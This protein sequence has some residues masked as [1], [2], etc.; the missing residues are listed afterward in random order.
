MTDT[1][2]PSTPLRSSSS[3]DHVLPSVELTSN[4]SSSGGRL[5]P[6]SSADDLLDTGNNRRSLTPTA[7]AIF[8]NLRLSDNP[9]GATHASGGTLHNGQTAFEL[10]PS[11][12]TTYRNLYNA[13]PSPAAVLSSEPIEQRP[14]TPS[15]PLGAVGAYLANL[16][17]EDSR[18]VAYEGSDRNR[19]P[20][21]DEVLSLGDGGEDNNSYPFD[22]RGEELF[23][24]PIYDIRLQDALRDVRGQLAD[25][26]RCM[27]RR[28]QAQDITTV[29]HNL[30]EQTL[31]ASRF[32]YPATR[33]VGFIGDS[34]MGKS[35]VINSILDQ[36]G[37]ARSNGDGAACTTVVTEFRSIDEEH[38]NSYTVEADF[39]DNTEI[40]ELLE[41]LLSAVRGYYTDA[42]REVSEP[43]EQENIRSAA[44][45]AWDTLQSLFPNQPELTLDF[46]SQEGQDAVEPIIARLE[47]WAMAGQDSR[48]GGRVNLQYSVVANNAEECMDQL[49]TIMA[50]PRDSDRPALWPFVKLI[51]VYLRSPVLRTGLIL[52]DLPGFRDLNYARVRATERY[53]RHSCD[54]VFIDV[55]ARETART[56]PGVEAR[57]I[58]DL[59]GRIKAVE[60]RIRQV[61]TLRRQAVGNRSQHLSAEQ[62]NLS[63]QKEALELELK[64]FLISRR[65]QRVTESLSRAWGS[66]TR[67][68]CVSN[69]LYAD[70]R[71]T[72]A[73]QASAYLELSGIK[74]LR[75][76]CQSVPADAQ[77]RAT[78]SFLQ[79]Q[80]PALLGSL[81]LWA[82]AR[83][84]AVTASRAETL[85]G[86]LDEASQTL[87]RS[88]TSRQSL[89]RLAQ[90]SLEEQFAGL[91]ERGIRNSRNEWRNDAINASRDWATW[92]HMTYAA[93][94]RNYGTYQTRTQPYRCWNEEILGRGITQLSNKWDVMLDFLD[95]KKD[96]L[97]EDVSNLFQ[98]ICDTVE[99][100]D[101]A[102]PDTLQMLIQNMTMRQRCIIHSIQ[103]SF[104]DLI[105]ATGK[106]RLDTTGGHDSSYIAGIMR[107]VYNS[108]R[109][110]YG[111]GSD[112][113]RKQIMDR[114]LSSSPLFR[115]FAT[116]IAGDFQGL[117]E[118][119]F[120]RLDQ[121]LRDEFS[122]LTQDLRVS[123][124][125]ERDES[126]AGRDPRHADELR[127]KVE[128]IQ[129]TLAHAC[130]IVTQVSQMAE[131]SD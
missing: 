17:L 63:E 102:A 65:N 84:D 23:R 122:N 94:C 95:D 3:P 128:R 24:A 30:Y 46:V 60:R 5:T 56:S 75:R 53:L 33:T 42:Y 57:Q 117:V 8:Q 127:Q 87:R 90:S 69:R 125:V 112:F 78:E 72:D 26:A 59:D 62:T 4:S 101:D 64:R 99:E 2:I 12:Y 25:L 16:N 123:V 83:S 97:S 68:F 119:I 31:A 79:N 55:N 71:A 116:S 44:R 10:A 98:G 21:L 20:N 15:S 92:H 52:A 89:V 37:L 118:G 82:S 67:I 110:Q 121:N 100:H 124:T 129:T 14:Q 32:A 111:T 36:E 74:E 48:P 105:C 114:H 81:I 47:E 70:H 86:V 58:H 77:L 103:A 113:R 80:L 85:R 35:S 126:E 51:R 38:P 39:M 93:W 131:D 88:L 49:D 120:T 54:E 22:I 6:A 27:G 108:C 66:Q 19:V 40:K 107:T 91:I 7:Q 11:S 109:E 106:M 13:T 43:E 45:R 9:S 61:R 1:E 130:Q 73:E 50:D 29:F 18:N 104:D 41:E 115:D 34:G 76:Y 28:E 96:D